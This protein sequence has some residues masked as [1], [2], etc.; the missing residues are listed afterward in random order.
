MTVSNDIVLLLMEEIAS[1]GLIITYSR[2]TVIP[3]GTPKKIG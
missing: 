3:G 1:G 2:L